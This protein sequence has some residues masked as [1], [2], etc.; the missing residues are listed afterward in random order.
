[1]KNKL[2]ES[3]LCYEYK[4][5]LFDIEFEEFKIWELLRTY[6]YIDIEQIYNN[7]QPLFPANKIKSHKKI[8]LKNLIRSLKLMLIKD[9]DFVFLNNPRRVRED[10]GKYYCVY[11]DLLIDLLK[12]DYK[13][14]TF[15]DPY[16]ALSPSS[17][18]SHFEPVKTENICYLDLM[19]YIF[20]IRKYFYKRIF[21]KK[22][23]KLHSI[24]KKIEND[25]EKEFNCDLSNIFKVGEEKILYMVLTYKT[26]KRIIKRINPKAVL[27]FYDVFPSKIVI[28]KIAKEL[29][30]PIVE[31]QHGV[32]TESNPIFLKY[33]DSKR[34][35]DCL[36]DYVLSYG[37]KLINTNMI[38]IKKENIYYVGSLFLNFKKDKYK[39]ETTLKKNILFIS[40]SNLGK[41]LSECAS[42]L[43][44]LLRDNPDY[45]IIYKMHP[46]EI[47]TNYPCLDKENITVI[48]NRDKD[49]Y[50][51]QAISSC[52]VGVYSTGIYEGLA[53]G[54][55][56][57]IL[58]N[59]YGTIEIK[60]ML[61]ESNNIKYVDNANEIFKDIKNMK[62]ANIFEDD[63]WEKV[64]FLKIKN[65]IASIV[66]K[67]N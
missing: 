49:L 10:D 22:Y 56:T 27:E 33:Y 39:N 1:M 25:I 65:I 50:Y 34:K 8:S 62:K 63:Y 61:K 12:P 58:N 64:D 6:I 2:F 48:N 35:Y 47:G 38:P 67:S 17:N 32:V 41:Y 66:N 20:K 40:Q 37:K 44:E 5:Q 57:Y 16:W 29:N 31:I 14:V 11:T 60:N 9:Q 36:P 46:Y 42:N 18:V 26:Y 13:C 45:H 55:K 30:I 52:Q 28:N 24:I 51:Y 19:E 21:N 7:L 4:N 53:F 3:F 23:K 15:E 59:C 54:L 43:A